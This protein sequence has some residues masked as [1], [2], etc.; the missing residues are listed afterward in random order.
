VGMYAR[1]QTT[2]NVPTGPD[3]EAMRTQVMEMISGHPGFA[4][5]FL[6][7]QV[8]I[9]F[10]AMVT[11][12]QTRQ[13]AVLASERSAARGPRPVTL[14]SDDVYEVEEDW[15]G[16]AAGERPEVATLLYFD[17]PLSAARLEA[18][19]WSGRERV[20]PAVR[21]LPGRVRSL[22]LFDA[23]EAKVALVTLATSMPALERIGQAVMNTELLPGE[24]PA[25][26]PGP[27]R[28]EVCRVVGYATEHAPS[29]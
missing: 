4:G 3:A 18:A 6:L 5:L 22:V 1:L 28:F 17:G 29:S 23:E 10:G 11:L 14:H 26:L 16:I 20:L 19:R 27:D 8:G 25:L 13:D 15:P 7:E 9:G 2:R 12:W 24:D 21:D